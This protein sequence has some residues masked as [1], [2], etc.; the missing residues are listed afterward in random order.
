VYDS[1]DVTQNCE[2][3]V[4]EEVSAAAALKEDTERR[5]KDGQDDLADVR[6][7]AGHVWMI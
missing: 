2:Q 5:E 6:T 4:Y 1:R 7:R 3:D